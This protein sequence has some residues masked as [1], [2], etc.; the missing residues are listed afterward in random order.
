MHYVITYMAYISSK[1]WTAYSLQHCLQYC[2]RGSRSRREIN[3]FT[4]KSDQFQISPAASPVIIHHIV[5]RIQLFIALL[6]CKIILLPILTTSLIY[7]SLKGCENV[8]FELGSERVNE[9]SS[10]SMSATAGEFWTSYRIGMCMY[11]IVFP[12]CFLTILASWKFPRYSKYIPT[13]T[14][15]GFP[16]ETFGNKMTSSLNQSYFFC[17]PL[18]D[19]IFWRPRSPTAGRQTLLSAQPRS[20]KMALGTRLLPTS[21]RLQAVPFFSRPQ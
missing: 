1:P 20:Q 18:L 9:A 14:L 17:W 8:L 6:R 7:C 12:P 21:V 13:F 16:E 4:P 15:V 5:W 10:E 2:T 3:P 19:C 11:V